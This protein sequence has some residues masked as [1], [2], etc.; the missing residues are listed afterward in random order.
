MM[1]YLERH[2][3]NL[4]LAEQKSKLAS[5]MNRLKGLNFLDPDTLGEV[6]DSLMSEEGWTLARVLA[7]LDMIDH[8]ERT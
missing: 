4:S 8:D 3:S 5:I 2:Y 7:H 1:K 6:V